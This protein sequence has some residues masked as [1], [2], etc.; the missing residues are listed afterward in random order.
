MGV[1]GVVVL[2]VVALVVAILVLLHRK[3]NSV[4]NSKGEVMPSVRNPLQ[5]FDDMKG[6]LEE[7]AIAM[8]GHRKKHGK[9]FSYWLGIFHSVVIC[10]PEGAKEVLHSSHDS[11]FGRIRLPYDRFAE[12]MLGS[13]I[14]T[15]DGKPWKDQRDL[16]NPSFH[17][18]HLKN[19]VSVFQEYADKTRNAW[20]E[21]IAKHIKEGNR[22]R[23]EIDIFPWITNMTLDIIGKAGFGFEFGAL[24]SN[25]SVY[26]KAYTSAFTYLL[27]RMRII[28][29]YEYLPIPQVKEAFANLE[30]LN[31][32]M[33]QMI[34]ERK[35]HKNPTPQNLL[36]SMIESNEN[37][38]G[39]Q[40]N[41]KM[42]KDNL[43]L[44]FV[45]GH[46]TT[47]STLMTAMYLLA[48]HPEHQD[49]VI[50]ELDGVVGK[51]EITWDDLGKLEYLTAVIRETL[52]LYPP[53]TMI[54]RNTLKDVTI[55]DYNVPKGT[56]AVISIYSIH[57]DPELWPEP[58]VFKPERFI[59]AEEKHPYAWIPFSS[60]PRVCLG[61]KFAMLEMKIS[62]FSLMS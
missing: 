49:K 36:D 18:T 43:F 59:N 30:L 46:D 35:Q 14:I 4:R 37:T 12:N 42:L 28:P 45:A 25:L 60:G 6:N 17:H 53:A 50:K 19:I 21:A 61:A 62:C 38:N 13:S 20:T 48:A 1:I 54:V 31:S 34:R 32:L 58:E 29:G 52:R 33:H 3:N 55:C 8:L 10:D 57:R 47:A 26:Q 22:G 11:D 5:V 39:Y 24:D 41:D 51:R 16:L 15:L 7:Q 27:N 9:I 2:V 40:L 56:L 23:K 44:L